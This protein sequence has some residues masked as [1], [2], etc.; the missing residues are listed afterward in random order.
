MNMQLI[1]ETEILQRQLDVR[2]GAY[3]ARNSFTIPGVR[4]LFGNTFIALGMRMHGR[5][6]K[7]REALSKKPGIMPVRGI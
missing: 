2:S 6:E 3:Q 1:T 4:Q 5:G 7:C